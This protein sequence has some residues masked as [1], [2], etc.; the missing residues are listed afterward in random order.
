MKAIAVDGPSGAGKST[1]VKGIAQKLG[2]VYVD[3]GAIYRAVGLFAAEA[4]IPRDT[5]KDVIPRLD[6]INVNLTYEDGVQKVYLNGK[7]VSSEIRTPE[8][9][10]YA[11]AVSALPEVRSKLLDLQRD[12]AR[13][14]NVIM[15]GR[16]IG[17]VV[18]PNA[19]VKIFLTASAEE[20]ARR[21][22]NELIG[23]GENVTYEQTLK[24]VIERDTNDENRAVAPLRPAEDAVIVDTTGR[25]KEESLALLFAEVEK[26]LGI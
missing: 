2:Y 26:R 24:E 1:M 12:I 5:I 6:E 23:K 20:R 16:D 11:S 7:D 9:S 22:Y 14:N 13:K 18:L 3:T 25:T 4:D 21:R 19:D 15:D 17:T 8:I 10:L